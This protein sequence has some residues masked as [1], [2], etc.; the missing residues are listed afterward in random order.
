MNSINNTDLLAAI[1]LSL[2]FSMKYSNPCINESTQFPMVATTFP[3]TFLGT[4]SLYVIA[5]I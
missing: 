5:G 1:I 2:L 3:F 4:D